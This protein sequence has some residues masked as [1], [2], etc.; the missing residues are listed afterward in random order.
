MTTGDYL[1]QPETVRPQELAFGVLHV[2][3]APSA[4]HQ[5]AVAA[6]FLAL[7]DH[8]G[9]HGLGEVLFAPLDVIL[10]VEAALIV[11]PDLLFV[12]NE[13]IPTIEDR[14]YGAPDLV[15]EVL[16]PR[17]R[18]GDTETR[19]GWFAE[20]GVRECWLVHLIE[21]W[22]DVVRFRDGAAVSR[23]R[24]AATE[25]IQSTVLPGFERTLTSILGR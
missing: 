5:R 15:V 14:V 13:R 24:F 6:L 4:S 1:R 12:E 21:R 10:D 16:S 2:A 18:V 9:S 17:C 22:V 11:Q 25:R 20:Y 7:N 8:I 3:D 23:D 19:L